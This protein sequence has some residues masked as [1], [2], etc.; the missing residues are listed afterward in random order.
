VR[1]LLQ[2]ERGLVRLGGVKEFDCLASV[3][4]C[5]SEILVSAFF[6]PGFVFGDLGVN[7]GEF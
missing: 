5:D 4:R 6:V 3:F 7:L 1:V 2:G